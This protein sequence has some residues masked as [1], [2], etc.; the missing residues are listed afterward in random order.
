MIKRFMMW[1][2]L[3]ML[4][5]CLAACTRQE[6]EPDGSSCSSSAPQSATLDTTAASDVSHVSDG[7]ETTQ[8]KML[9]EGSEIIIDLYDNPTSR[10]L[11]EMLP[12]ELTFEEYNGTEKISYLPRSLTTEG[13]PEGYTPAAGDVTLYAPWG[14]LAV[15]YQNFRY[16]NGLIPLG[17][18]HTGLEILAGM[19]RDFTVTLEKVT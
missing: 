12:L 13:A 9:V 6:T 5:L 11:L 4:T 19:E 3:L 1:G 8:I 14:N 17:K 16:S 10:E 15:F 2:M 7:K 18:I